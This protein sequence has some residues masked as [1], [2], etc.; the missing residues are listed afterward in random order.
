VADHI[1]HATETPTTCYYDVQCLA[2]INFLSNDETQG[3]MHSRVYVNADIVYNQIY[4]AQLIGATCFSL[5]AINNPFCIY[6]FFL[7]LNPV[8]FASCTNTFCKWCEITR[9]MKRSAQ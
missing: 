3:Y 6:Y 9:G 8:L 5:L 7:F 4:Y 2:E 1:Q